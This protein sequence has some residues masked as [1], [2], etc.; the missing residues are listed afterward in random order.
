MVAAAAAAAAAA[1]TVAEGG[2]V[3]LHCH[4]CYHSYGFS[5]SKRGMCGER[6]APPSS[7]VG[8]G[9]GHGGE[10]HD[11]RVLS[12]TEKRIMLGVFLSGISDVADEMIGAAEVATRARLSRP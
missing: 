9:G 12:P 4:A 3:V 10:D 7:L 5:L 1:A 11:F 8:H 2:A 6:T